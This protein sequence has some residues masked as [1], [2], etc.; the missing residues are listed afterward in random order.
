[1]LKFG[2]KRVRLHWLSY[3]GANAASVKSATETS[4]KQWKNCFKEE[5]CK[6]AKRFPNIGTELEELLYGSTLPVVYVSWYEANE[7]TRWLSKISGKK[8]RLPT[9]A[10]W[11][12]AARAGKKTL[13]PWGNRLIG[14]EKC[15]VCN[16]NSGGFLAPVD[17]NKPEYGNAPYG[18]LYYMY[19]N[20]AEWTCSPFP[21]VDNLPSDKQEYKFPTGKEN[22]CLTPATYS[23]GGMNTKGGSYE[24]HFNSEAYE[25]RPDGG[26]DFLVSP[27][28][29]YWSIGFRVIREE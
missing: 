29:R 25:D 11:E 23:S 8:Y 16:Y 13:Y 1:M 4:F 26:L 7:Y 14:I 12:Y 28:R 6:K 18:G 20:A 24:M 5:G 27:S 2:I 15:K 9:A 3:H 21:I 19:G 17:Y 10:E 22:I